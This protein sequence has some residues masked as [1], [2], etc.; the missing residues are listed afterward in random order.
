MARARRNETAVLALVQPT[1]MA[2]AAAAAAAARAW[3]RAPL[4]LVVA[5]VAAAACGLS[6]W[7]VR[8][9][10]ARGAA[11]ACDMTFNHAEWERVP[12]PAVFPCPTQ[13]G[14]RACASAGCTRAVLIAHAVDPFR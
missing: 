8:G 3:T 6:Q 1:R 9:G 12:V 13:S 7:H 4:A 11:G 2:A 5:L 14:D 10:G